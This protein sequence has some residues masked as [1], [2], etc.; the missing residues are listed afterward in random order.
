ML[1]FMFFHILIHS[2]I[3]YLNIFNI[4]SII[5][6]GINLF[7]TIYS[8]ININTFLQNNENNENNNLIINKFIKNISLELTPILIILQQLDEISQLKQLKSLEEKYPYLSFI[9]PIKVDD[10]IK[11]VINKYFMYVNEIYRDK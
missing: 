7:N 4:N 6:N 8:S 10:E 1:T 5:K 2:S 11:D 9:F 3:L